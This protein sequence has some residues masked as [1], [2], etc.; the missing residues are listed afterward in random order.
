M[1]TARRSKR[2]AKKTVEVSI[3]SPRRPAQR[4]K[5][6]GGNQRN[7][8]TGGRRKKQAGGEAK[9]T[10]NTGRQSVEGDL[11]RKILKFVVGCAVL[12]LILLEAEIQRHTASTKMATNDRST[13]SDVDQL[14][15]EGFQG[16]QSSVRP[17]S[18]THQEVE[19]NIER[20]TRNFITL[21]IY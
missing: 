18:A 9:D 8:K 7:K 4:K 15:D 12:I 17:T 3:P 11:E 16:E 13:G 2:L 6:T 19:G 20:T 10:A 14:M 5:Q 1:D 21:A